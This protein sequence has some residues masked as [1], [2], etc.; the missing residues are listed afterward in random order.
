LIKAH[1]NRWLMAYLHNQLGQINQALGNLAAAGEYYHSSYNLREALEDPEGMALALNHLGEV[2][3]AEK[4][5]TRAREQYEQARALYHRLGDRGGLLRSFHGLGLAAL[6]LGEHKLAQEHF[7][8]GLRLA[9]MADATPLTLS[10]LVTVG[11]FLLEA[12]VAELGLATLSIV[13]HHPA[14]EQNTRE[15]AQKLLKAHGGRGVTIS[16]PGWPDLEAAGPAPHLDT[17]LMTLQGR[18]GNLERVPPAEQ[19]IHI[20]AEE[21]PLIE[22]LTERELEVLQQITL[23]LTNREIAEKLVIALSTVKSHIKNIYGKMGVSNRV[24]AVA[25]AQELGLT[26]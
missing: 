19:A 5:Y 23:G 4:A 13:A 21:Q 7:I 6:G 8:Q 14:A 16:I 25:R 2:A 24:Q 20:R 15:R 18:L 3:L 22:P 10:L 1:G 11:T 26:D 9:T 12:G 17:V